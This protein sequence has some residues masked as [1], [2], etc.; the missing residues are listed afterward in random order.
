MTEPAKENVLSATNIAK[1][2]G[3]SDTKVKKAIK[4]LG[5]EPASKRG[6]CCF[7][8]RDEIGRIKEKIG[9]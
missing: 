8:A 4:D 6:V 7:Y 5:I 1:E 2:L 3:V 9:A